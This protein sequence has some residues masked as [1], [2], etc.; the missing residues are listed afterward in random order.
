MFG[1]PRGPDPPLDSTLINLIFHLVRQGAAGWTT[2]RPQIS[3][4][5]A[6]DV[7]QLP[8]ARQNSAWCTSGPKA[9]S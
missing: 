7:N 2:G 8:H 3:P 9:T 6:A 5:V 4:C 1:H